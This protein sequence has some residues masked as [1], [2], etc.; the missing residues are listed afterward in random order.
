MLVCASASISL[1]LQIILLSLVTNRYQ[2][3]TKYDDLCNVQ[4]KPVK[5]LDVDVD[6]DPV[7]APKN[8]AANLLEV[9]GEGNVFCH[10]E[11]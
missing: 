9:L 3:K 4:Y 8:L 1:N 2:E 11:N 10:G 7:K 5:M 6:K